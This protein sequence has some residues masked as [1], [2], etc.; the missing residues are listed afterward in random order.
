MYCA[1]IKTMNNWNE[2]LKQSQNGNKNSY[3]HFLTEVQPFVRSVIY[4]KVQNL[5]LIDDILQETLLAIHNSLHTYDATRNAKSWISV[6]ARN[7]AIDY[8]RS[9]QHK[10]SQA[11]DIE[12]LKLEGSETN[13]NNYD[14]EKAMRQ[15][16]VKQ[17]EIIVKM[18]VEGKTAKQTALELE[19]TE[20]AVKTSAHRAYKL[21]KEFLEV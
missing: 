20:S 11:E 19:M 18:K 14:L 10:L 2:L 7:K 6:I 13:T 16:S 9:N 21:I 1:I 4:T 5:S 12:N 17:Q 8:L 15:V 3:K